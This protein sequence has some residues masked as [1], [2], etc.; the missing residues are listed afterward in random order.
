MCVYLQDYY[1]CIRYWEF[2]QYETSFF[3]S[4]NISYFKVYFL[5]SYYTHSNSLMITVYMIKF[6]H[7]ICVF[8]SKACFLQTEYNQISFCIRMTICYLVQVIVFSC[9]CNCLY[10]CIH[11]CDFVFLFYRS[12]KTCSFLPHLLLFLVFN[13]FLFCI[14]FIPLIYFDSN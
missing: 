4:N 13:I 14:V 2:Y 11:I 1:I 3:V 9:F 5:I 7:L 10:D 6:F 12:H 8:E